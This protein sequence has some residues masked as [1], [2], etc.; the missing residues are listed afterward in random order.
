MKLTRRQ[1]T[2]SAAALALSTLA[3]RPAVGQESRAGGSLVTPELIL[4]NGR[5]ATLDRANPDPEAIAIAEGT[6]LAVGSERE[7]RA[8]AGARTRILDLGGRRVIPGLDDSHTHL[9]QRADRE[10]PSSRYART[11]ADHSAHAC[12]V[13]GHAHAVAGTSPM[14]APELRGFWGAL[15]CSCFAL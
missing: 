2:A 9:I 12:A 5:F 15:G 6:F 14:A 13:H 11:R 1:M 7:V 4:V 10:A 3:D 8:L